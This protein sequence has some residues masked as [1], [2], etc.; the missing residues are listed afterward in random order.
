LKKELHQIL[1]HI[2]KH[3]EIGIRELSWIMYRKHN[4]HRDFYGLTAL[5]EAGYIGFTGPISKQN[6]GCLNV[7][8]QVRAFQAY[9]QGIDNPTYD[10]AT[11][12]MPSNDDAHLFIAPKSI[13]YFNLRKEQRIGWYLVSALTLVCS[14]ASGVVVGVLTKT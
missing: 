13:E 11:L 9:S 10:N 7:Y 12:L 3:D 4:D 1:E 6:D 5:L 2:Y 8:N 14:I